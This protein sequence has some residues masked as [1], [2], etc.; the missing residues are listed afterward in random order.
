MQI[1]YNL[2]NLGLK[3]SFFNGEHV[4]EICSSFANSKHL[5]VCF[6][7][8]YLSVLAPIPCRM[9]L[10]TSGHRTVTVAS[11]QSMSDRYPGV[12]IMYIEELD[13]HCAYG[14]GCSP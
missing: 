2:R 12:S 14:R 3:P 13:L 1:K 8:P 5:S 6:W 11:S 4:Q 10:I 7:P 9:P